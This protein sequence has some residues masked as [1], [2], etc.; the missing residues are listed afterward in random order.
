[1][2]Y[3]TRVVPNKPI[4]LK[5]GKVPNLRSATKRKSI[6]YSPICSLKKNFKMYEAAIQK[7]ISTTVLL[8][9]EQYQTMLTENKNELL[10]AISN[11]LE[12]MSKE[13]SNL[14]EKYDSI[15]TAV[16]ENSKDITSP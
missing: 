2:S 14:S 15:S 4:V 1:M 13:M 11:Q 6:E 16:T 5:L 12:P 3:S 10:T 8:N 7:I 9:N